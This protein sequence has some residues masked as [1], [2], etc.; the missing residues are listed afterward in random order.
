MLCQRFKCAGWTMCVQ[1]K[2]HTQFLQNLGL[3]KKYLRGDWKLNI[4]LTFD[5]CPN[6][7]FII[8]MSKALRVECIVQLRLVTRHIGSNHRHMNIL[9]YCPLYK[10][11]LFCTYKPCYWY[12]Y[13]QKLFNILIYTW[14]IIFLPFRTSISWALTCDN[15]DIR[16]IICLDC[17]SK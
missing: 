12:K 4:Q 2:R 10:N 5:K 11:I 3:I 7:L 1:F 17:H 13:Q 15:M 14:L 8:L 6:N 9:W 16:C